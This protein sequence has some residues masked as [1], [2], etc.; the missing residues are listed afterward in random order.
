MPSRRT[1]YRLTSYMDRGRRN[2]VSEASRRT[3]VNRPERPFTP[4]IAVR[5]GEDAPID[6]NRLDIMRRYADGVKFIGNDGQIVSG[7]L[8]DSRSPGTV[9]C[10]TPPR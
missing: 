4:V 9:A 7:R 8:E 10:L 3:A 2:F 5:P 1:F 6:T